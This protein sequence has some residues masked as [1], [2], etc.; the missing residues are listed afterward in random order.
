M[1]SFHADSPEFREQT[2]EKHLDNFE[3]QGLWTKV[4]GYF[5][6]KVPLFTLD[7][8]GEVYFVKVL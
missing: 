7:R 2:Y 4:P 8:P 1:S 5:P 3:A 6:K